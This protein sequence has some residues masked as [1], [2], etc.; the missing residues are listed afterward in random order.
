MGI[1]SGAVKDGTLARSLARVNLFYRNE[2]RNIEQDLVTSHMGA[3][4]R[5]ARSNGPNR[6]FDALS[7]EIAPGLFPP[8]SLICKL[9]EAAKKMFKSLV[10]FRVQ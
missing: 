9:D 10:D 2:P 8:T 3:G 4:I 1:A 5:S 6:I 7:H